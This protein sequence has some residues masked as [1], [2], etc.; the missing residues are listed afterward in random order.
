[1]E[2]LEMVTDFT[3]ISTL[4]QGIRI[5][6][7]NKIEPMPFNPQTFDRGVNLVDEIIRQGEEKV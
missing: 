5:K 2:L 6:I 4:K 7:N 3:P 1:M